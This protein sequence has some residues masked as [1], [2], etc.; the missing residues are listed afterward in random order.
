I[1]YRA[2]TQQKLLRLLKALNLCPL[3]AA[4]QKPLLYKG[5][6]TVRPAAC[7]VLGFIDRSREQDWL[8]LVL[9]VQDRVLCVCDD[10][11]REM[12]TPAFGRGEAGGLT[13]GGAAASAVG[14]SVS[15][16]AAG[17]HAG[18]TPA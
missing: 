8:V 7:E 16:A 15:G 1:V 9:R 17:D 12:Q 10:Y 3:T 4:V 5:M 18:G 6:D 13:A 11:L 14:G 2:P